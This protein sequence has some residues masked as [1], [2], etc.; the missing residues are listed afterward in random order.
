[1]KAHEGTVAVRVCTIT[2]SDT[3]RG[4]DDTSGA[5]LAAGCVDAG[6]E[7]LAHLR[8]PDEPAAIEAALAEAASRHADAVLLTGG[9]GIAARDVTYEVVAAR[10]AKTLDGF[11]ETFRRLSYDEIGPRAMLSRAVAG[12]TA[13]GRVLVALPGSRGAVSLAMRALIAPTLGHMVAL[14]RP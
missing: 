3:R 2:V 7:H 10:L 1:M 14:A 8:V 9:T 13:E 5:L 12:V 6:F 11:G 4:D